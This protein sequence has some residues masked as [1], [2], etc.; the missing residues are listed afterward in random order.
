M[1]R[2]YTVSGESKTRPTDLPDGFT[3]EET[4]FEAKIGAFY[5]GDNDSITF[6]DRDG[7]PHLA[8]SHGSNEL[9]FNRDQIVKLRDALTEW[10]GDVVLTVD[11]PE[12]DRSS[13]YK[14]ADGDTWKYDACN[15]W[16]YHGRRNSFVSEPYSWLRVTNEYGGSFPWDLV[17][18]SD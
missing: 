1:A 14:D 3:V 4:G 8:F 12:P 17:M 6:E 18:S 11:S 5:D 7:T 16:R 9:Y 15:G 2:I 13:A 10:L